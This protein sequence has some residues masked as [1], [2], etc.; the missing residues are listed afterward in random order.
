MSELE[1][2]EGV[3]K[4]SENASVGYCPQ[5][6]GSF[7]D[8]DLTLKNSLLHLELPQY[9]RPLHHLLSYESHPKKPTDE[10]S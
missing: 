5:D 9:F 6:S 4:W 8:N 10:I 2:I 1:H 7:F 3:V